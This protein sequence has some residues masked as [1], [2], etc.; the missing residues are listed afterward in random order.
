MLKLK[1]CKRGIYEKATLQK[2]FDSCDFA[3][4]YGIASCLGPRRYYGLPCK[5]PE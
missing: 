5:R 3:V 1:P 2:F 4:F